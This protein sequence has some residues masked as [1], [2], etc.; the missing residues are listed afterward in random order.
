[1]LHAKQLNSCPCRKC[2]KGGD[3]LVNGRYY[4]KTLTSCNNN[5]IRS[6]FPC[7]EITTFDLNQQPPVKDKSTVHCI[8]DQKHFK[9]FKTKLDRKQIHDICKPR[10][11]LDNTNAEYYKCVK[12]FNDNDYTSI[13]QPCFGLDLATDFEPFHYSHNRKYRGP[14]GI[15]PHK[16]PCSEPQWDSMDPRLMSPPHSP[17]DFNDKQTLDAPPYTGEV[18]LNNIYDNRL[19]NYGKNYKNYTDINGGQIRYYVDKDLTPV[20]FDPLFVM[21]SNVQSE[22]FQDPMTSSKFQTIRDPVYRDNKNVSDY[23][24]DRDAIS[25]RENLMHSQM[26]IHESA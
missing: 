4:P 6:D 19:T 17:L 21:D 11:I 3:N 10:K 1:M 7:S 15:R 8:N 16:P 24:F 20:L 25:F 18:P 23:Q 13:K 5:A 12:N 26:A 2:N 14:V 9:K 22:I